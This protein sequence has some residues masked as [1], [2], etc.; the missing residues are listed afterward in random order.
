MTIHLETRNTVANKFLIRKGIRYVHARREKATIHLF[1]L[2]TGGFVKPEGVV[3]RRE[4][5]FG[6]Q[7]VDED[8]IA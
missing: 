3:A 8:S 4:C 7:Y 6:I 1:P 2:I 5:H